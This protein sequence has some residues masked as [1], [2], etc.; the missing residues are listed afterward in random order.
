MISKDEKES[1]LSRKSEANANNKTFLSLTED[2][3]VASKTETTQIESSNTANIV[4]DIICEDIKSFGQKNSNL[5]I[6]SVHYAVS[7]PDKQLEMIYCDS[8]KTIGAIN[9]QTVLQDT[10]HCLDKN[11]SESFY[12]AT[13]TN[14]VLYFKGRIYKP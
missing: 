12:K 4:S 6:I 11:F 2:I 10:E 14:K 9:A 7:G 13:D 5:F 8:N 1:V 3:V